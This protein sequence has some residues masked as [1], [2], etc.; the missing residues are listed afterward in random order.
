M[1]D[2]DEEE[3]EPPPLLSPGFWAALAAGLVCVL[4]A[5][6]LLL[7]AVLAGPSGP[8]GALGRQDPR[9]DEGPMKR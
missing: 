8:K 4:A 6:G 1:T 2:P 3:D 9:V 7:S 5:I